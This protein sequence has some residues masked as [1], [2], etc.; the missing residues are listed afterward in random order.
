MHALLQVDL[1]DN[2][3]VAPSIYR[4]KIYNDTR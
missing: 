4:G 1:S 3:T 2:K